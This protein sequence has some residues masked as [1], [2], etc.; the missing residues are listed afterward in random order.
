MLQGTHDQVY[1]NVRE[2]REIVKIGVASQRQLNRQSQVLLSEI[3]L[4][5]IRMLLRNIAQIFNGEKN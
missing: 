4:Q 3:V 1:R 5:P 2:Y